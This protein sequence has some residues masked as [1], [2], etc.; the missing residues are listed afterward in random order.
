MSVDALRTSLV[1]L[2]VLVA[3]RSPFDE[4]HSARASVRVLY[5]EILAAAPAARRCSEEIPRSLRS[6]LAMP[7]GVT[8]DHFGAS[9]TFT[10]VAETVAA[11]KQACMESTSWAAAAT[12]ER[13]RSLRVQKQ[14]VEPPTPAAPSPPRFDGARLDA[15]ADAEQHRV[16][17]LLERARASVVRNQQLCKEVEAMQQHA[18]ERRRPAAAASVS[19]ALELLQRAEAAEAA[20]DAACAPSAPLPLSLLSVA[21]ATPPVALREELDEK[22]E[23]EPVAPLG[24]AGSPTVAQLTSR[25][26]AKTPRS[27]F[28]AAAHAAATP[29]MS[30]IEAIAALESQTLGNV[31]DLDAESL[32]LLAKE[33]NTEAAVVLAKQRAA[34]A[35]KRAAAAKQKVSAEEEARQ[36]RLDAMLAAQHRLRRKAAAAPKRRRAAKGAKR[37]AAANLPGGSAAAALPS[38]ATRSRQRSLVTKAQ[39]VARERVKSSQFA[40]HVVQQRHAEEEKEKFEARCVTREHTSPELAG[41][42]LSPPLAHHHLNPTLTPPPS[43]PSLLQIP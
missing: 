7:S 27:Q 39:R 22:E 13:E 2:H 25:F 15:L 43:L 41:T 1:G 17:T 23:S 11:L 4:V 26:P 20:N 12:P 40:T 18:E 42:P 32:S 33:R 14:P 31:G 10:D 34:T 35:V 19:P 36:Q 3:T 28:I 6:W 21:T 8:E 37:A 29:M 9:F 30:D 5:A 38:P 24:A 16:A